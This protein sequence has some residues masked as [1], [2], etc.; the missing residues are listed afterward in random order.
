MVQ[1]STQVTVDSIQDVSEIRRISFLALGDSY[2]IGQSVAESERWPNQLR[3]QINTNF[4]SLRIVGVN[5]IAR[6]GWTT[7]D[8]NS[9]LNNENITGTYDLVSLLI[10]VNNQYRGYP[11]EDYPNEFKN[12]LTRA[13]SYAGGKSEHVFVVSIPDYGYTPFG[14]SNQEKISSDI[15]AYNVINKRIADEY[16]INY[17]N[18]TPISRDGLNKPELVAS[19]NLHPSGEQYKL[20][21]EKII[22]DENFHQLLNK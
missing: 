5:I 14:E 21:V 9:A 2:T 12:L 11:I 15:D 7:Q 19:D 16:G 22:A 8:L 10:G 1:D 3:D 4:D 17:Y 18:I 13:I 20:W 6:T